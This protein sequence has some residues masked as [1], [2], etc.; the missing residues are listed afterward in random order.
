MQGTGN[1]IDDQ[2]QENGAEPPGMVHV[3]EVE[4]VQDFIQANPVS[5][6]IFR[7]SGILDDH[8]ADDGEDGKQNKERNRKLERPEKVIENGEKSAFFR[9]NRFVRFFHNVL[10]VNV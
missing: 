1:Q 2:E 10:L 9:F 8:R 7:A 4:K 6:N 5:L 3:E